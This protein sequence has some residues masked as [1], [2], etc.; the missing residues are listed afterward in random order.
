MRK[1]EVWVDGNKRVEQ[2][3]G[4][5]H[6]TYLNRSLSLRPGSHAVT[7]FAAGWDNWLESKSFTL[8]VK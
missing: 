2:S 3:D 6:Y 8:D 7:V 5:S 1:V 4:F